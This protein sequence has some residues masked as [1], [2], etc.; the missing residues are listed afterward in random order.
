MVL[1][2][3]EITS[4][5]VLYYAF[6]VLA[7]HITGRAVVGPPRPARSDERG[8]ATGGA[9]GRRGRVLTEFDVLPGGVARGRGGDGRGA[10]SARVRRADPLAWPEPGPRADRADLGGWVG[11]YGVRA[12]DRVA[13]DAPGL[14]RH[15]PGARRNPRVGH[16]SRPPVRAAVAMAV[17]PA[18]RAAARPC[19]GSE[20]GGAQPVLPHTGRGVQRRGVRHVRRRGQPG[21]AAD[22]ARRRYRNCGGRARGLAAPGR[23]PAASATPPS[24]AAPASAHGPHWS[25]S[26]WPPPRPRS[27]CSPPCP[28]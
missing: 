26:R 10:V 12:A 7:G 23:S 19:R 13:V 1:C 16:D 14:A 11:E 2:A 15:L 9:G 3:T 20:S 27:A 22:R 25:C 6:P 4:W 18:H 5:G 24:P 28:R 17:A 8:F 21:A